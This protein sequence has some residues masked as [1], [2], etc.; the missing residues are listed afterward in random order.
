M[1]VFFT[2]N[3]SFYPS[4]SSTTSVRAD[5]SILLLIEEIQVLWSQSY[6]IEILRCHV[7]GY[8]VS[9]AVSNVMPCH[10]SRYDRHDIHIICNRETKGNNQRENKNK[11]DKSKEIK[12]NKKNGSEK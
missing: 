1:C 7:P 2:L 5:S 6:A 10:H 12:K 9:T 8:A 4:T 3:R 11:G